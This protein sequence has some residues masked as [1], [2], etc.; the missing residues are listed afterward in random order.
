MLASLAYGAS[1]SSSAKDV[2][3]IRFTT[4]RVRAIALSENNIGITTS[5]AFSYNASGVLETSAN[6]ENP[7]QP[8]QQVAE[9]LQMSPRAGPR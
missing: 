8:A 4:M 5:S 1:C 3:A 9:P 6:F 2:R 7:A